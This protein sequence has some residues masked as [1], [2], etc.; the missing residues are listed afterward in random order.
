MTSQAQSGQDV[1]LIA[2]GDLSSDQFKC[3]KAGTADFRVIL[4][5]SATASVP[6]GVLQDDPDAAGK[7]A[8]V[9]V[10]GNTRILAGGTVS[11]GVV[12]T[13]LAGGTCQ[14]KNGSDVILGV[15]LESGVSGDVVSIILNPTMP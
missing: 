2:G 12:Q 9:R 6:I 10:Y 4:V 8:T 3:V 5:T 15:A 13:M 7:S 1:S 11:R 14:D